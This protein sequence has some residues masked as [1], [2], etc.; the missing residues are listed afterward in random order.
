MRAE[1][2]RA[3]DVRAHRWMYLDVWRW[4][5]EP[6][7]HHLGRSI[8]QDGHALHVHLALKHGVLMGARAA[9][10]VP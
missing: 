6:V 3:R 7:S 9:L 8:S 4:G 5:A 10:D 2:R 1:A